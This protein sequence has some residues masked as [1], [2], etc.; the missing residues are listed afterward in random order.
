[1]HS[2]DNL[3]DL[4]HDSIYLKRLAYDEM[5]AMQ[6][7][8]RIARSNQLDSKQTP[9][10]GSNILAKKLLALLPFALTKGQNQL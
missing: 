5:L 7:A 6:L 4:T 10:L 1:M 3:D 9:I 2:P 8:L